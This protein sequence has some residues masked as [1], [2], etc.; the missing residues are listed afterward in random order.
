MKLCGAAY[1]PN[2][3]SQPELDRFYENLVSNFRAN[4]GVCAITSGMACVQYDVAQAT[5]DCD[6]LCA[7]EFDELFLDQLEKTKFGGASCSYRGHLTPPLDARWM[8][9]GWTSHFEWKREEGV[10]HLDVFGV[11]PRASSPWTAD[12]RGLLAG[13]HTVAEMKRTDR[14]KD[15]PFATALGVKL[16]DAGD[17]R[18]WLH[19][20]DVDV[21]RQMATRVPCPPNIVALRP[22][23]ELLTTDDPRLEVAVFAEAM[24]WQRLDRLRL[25]IHESFMRRFRSV[26]TKDPDVDH[27]DLRIQHRVRLQHA[28]DHLPPNPLRDYG[29]DRL[30]AE[31]REETLRFVVQGSLDWLPD[32]SR[33]FVGL[34]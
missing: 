1:H 27:H 15:W 14:Q 33:N 23:L 31:A 25:R 2:M 8:R 21:I 16:L 9:G 3:I 30:V 29:I 26:V 34:A 6:V 4:G 10:A 28:L 17:L 18:G 24:F 11:A 12:I 5:K 19:L 22:V 13:M 20:F 32:A 7:A